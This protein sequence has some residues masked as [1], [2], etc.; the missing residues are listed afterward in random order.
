MIEKLGHSRRLQTMRREW[1]DEAKPRV[2]GGGG[3]EDEEHRDRT[4]GG[5]SDGAGARG[6]ESGAGGERLDALA[7][8]GEESRMQGEG[9]GEDRTSGTIAA[10][11]ARAEDV[12]EDMGLFVTDDE[13]DEFGEANGREGNDNG[14][15]KE[16]G[17]ADTPLDD[18][19]LDAL[20]AEDA[21]R[22]A[23]EPGSA[24]RGANKG[25]ETGGGGV[26][27]AEDDFDDE[28][29]AMAGLDFDY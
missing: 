12:D 22:G 3:A 17:D 10:P 21:A 5:G 18:D 16:G 8:Q 27:R 4:D 7:G 26:Q 25:I 24:V 14:V 6:R 20:L 1:I 9:S 15:G 29:E 13:D 23:S 28:M 11:R 2:G 19:E